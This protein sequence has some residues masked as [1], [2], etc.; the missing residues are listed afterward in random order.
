MEIYLLRHGDA[1]SSG[2]IPDKDRALTDEGRRQVTQSARAFAR[3]TP[4]APE[5]LSS[6]LARAL[7]SAE[8]VAAQ[9]KPLPEV[10]TTEALVPPG[11][12]S[13]LIDL[14]KAADA[15]RVLLVGHEPLLGRFLWAMI[16]G[17][18]AGAVPMRKASLARVDLSLPVL[19]DGNLIWLIPPEILKDMGS[20]LP[21]D[22]ESL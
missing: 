4:R 14:I 16:S 2:G 1:E 22:E 7:Q 19:G 12:F 10:K 3:M 6:P 17:V 8:L 11:D 18:S 13:E 21:P 15:E 5:I 9:F 20:R